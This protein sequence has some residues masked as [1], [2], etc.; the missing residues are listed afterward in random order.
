MRATIAVWCMCV[1]V[2]IGSV[3]VSALQNDDSGRTPVL[4]YEVVKTYPHDPKAFTQGLVF[5]NGFLYESTGLKGQSS[6]RKVRLETGEVTDLRAVDKQFFAEGLTDWGG[7]LLQLTWETNIGF[8][9]DLASFAPLSTFT[10]SGEGWGL[11]HDDTQLIMSDGTSALRFLD[12]N[13]QREIRRV[14]VRDGSKAIERL[15][16]LEFVKGEVFANVW[17]TD[18]IAI[19]APSTGKVT[20]W[21]DLAK[22]RAPSR[23]GEDVLNGIAYDAGGN[24]LFVTGKLWSRLYEIKIRR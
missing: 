11:T 16:E 24:R 4:A 8:V 22:L 12:P 18:R 17:L 1:A 20:A 15:N 7:K 5:R 14:T 3:A 6:L 19:I 10:Y 2:A 9:Y 23:Q 21:L 13:T